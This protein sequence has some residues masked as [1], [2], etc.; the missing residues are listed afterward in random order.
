MYLRSSKSFYGLFLLCTLLV[1][2]YS[3]SKSKKVNLQQHLGDGK[4]RFSPVMEE[5]LAQFGNGRYS[6]L[7]QAMAGTSKSSSSASTAAMS[8]VFKFMISHLMIF[9]LSRHHRD[10]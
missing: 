5:A 2:G 4:M 6:S 9:D 1:V 10:Q 3:L 7:I 8:K